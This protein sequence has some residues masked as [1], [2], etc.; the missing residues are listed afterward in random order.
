MGRSNETPQHGNFEYF[1]VCG[2][3][4]LRTPRCE[5]ASSLCGRE[6]VSERKDFYANLEYT[7]EPLK[8]RCS[9]FFREDFRDDSTILVWPLVTWNAT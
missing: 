2:L 8:L 3:S 5:K 6:F 1:N 4:T 9:D 7:N